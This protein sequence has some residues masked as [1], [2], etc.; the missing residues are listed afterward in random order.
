MKTNNYYLKNK[1]RI[2]REIK[3]ALPHYK[4]FIAELYGADLAEVITAETLNRFEGLLSDIPY[5][6][7]NDNLLTENLYLSAAVLAFYQ[8]LKARG[9]PIEEIA[10]IIYLGTDAFY[11]SFPFSL[12]L[13][14]Q[15]RQ[16]FS[17]K[18]IAQRR[19]DAAL[20][21]Q[22][23]YPGD[24]VFQIITGDGA[25]FEFGVDY[26]ECGIVKYLSEQNAPELA[27]YLC[28]LD[29]PMCAAMRVGL[30]RTETIAQGGT[31]C[32]FR[33]CRQKELSDFEPD[34]VK[35]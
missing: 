25:D 14:W 11:S 33:F 16:L 28:W 2:L 3:F 7:G 9:K 34:F 32:D 18:R 29:Y 20:S 24:W 31:K 6:G 23:R 35:N 8:S 26:T 27:P 5:I 21:Q 4:R 10:R 12:L 30:I 1:K 17:Q 13:R 19:R 15:G 22:Q